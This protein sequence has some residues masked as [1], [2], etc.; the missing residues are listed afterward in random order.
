[1]NES[2]EFQQP[3]PQE[4]IST[5]KIRDIEER[6]R[7]VKDR[8]LLVGRTHIEEREKTFS[9]I[10]SLKTKVI[11]LTKDNIRIQE[12]LQRITEQ[13]NKTARSED[14]AI[15]QRQFNLFRK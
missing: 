3:F 6:L 1:M 15:L 11:K 10:Q 14:L 2:S 9:E 7:L 12:I 5:L 13:L 8:L 4:G